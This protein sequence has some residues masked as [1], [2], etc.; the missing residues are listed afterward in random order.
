MHCLFGSEKTAGGGSWNLGKTSFTYLSRMKTFIASS[1]LSSPVNVNG[2]E[3]YLNRTF[4]IALQKT[5]SA[6]GDY[7]GREKAIESPW[8]FGIHPKDEVE[9]PKMKKINLFG[10]M[11]QSFKRLVNRCINQ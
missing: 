10:M 6:V 8:T 7:I 5:A 3:K 11:R 9:F 4:G 1:N 2:E